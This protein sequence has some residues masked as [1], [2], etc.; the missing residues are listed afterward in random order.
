MFIERAIKLLKTGILGFIIPESWLTNPSNWNL[1]KYLIENVS[2]LKIVDI[3]GMVFPDATVDTVVL[4]LKKQNPLNHKVNILFAK[5]KKGIEISKE[6]EIVQSDYSQLKDFVMNTNIDKNAIKLIKKID[7]KSIKLKEICK[8]TRGIETGDN[9]KYLSKI[10]EG[11]GYLPIITGDD[12]ERYYPPSN[13][14]HVKYGKWLSNPKSLDIFKGD[15]IVLQR[16]KNQNLKRRL[17]A[18]IDKENRLILD[19]VHMIYEIKKEYNPFYILSLINSW[20]LNFYFK[21]FSMYP[22]I[23]ADDLDN[24]PIKNIPQEKQLHFITLAD[25]MLSLNK[26]LQEIR[27]KNTLQKQKIQ[28]EIKKTDKE[29]DELVYQLYGITE[30][31]KKI[32]EESLG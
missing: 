10:K 31:E 21:L 32:I 6:N 15:K 20:L 28:E 24:L 18:T 17:V 13:K 29:I 3:P 5:P 22:R 26:N 25:K 23:N 19:S 12:I 1:R 27:D 7:E 2:I 11:K 4:I 14:Y 16:I 9:K 8:N 30:E